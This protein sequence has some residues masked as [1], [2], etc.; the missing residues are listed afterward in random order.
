MSTE[1]EL[2]EE[3][4]RSRLVAFDAAV[5]LRFPGRAFQLTLVGGGALVLLGCLAR[6]TADLDA[7]SVPRELVDLMQQFDIN[8]R[9]NAYV[10]NFAYGFEDRLV[11]LDLETKAVQC[12]AA[13]LEDI[14]AAKLHSSRPTDEHDVRRPEV[15]A[16]LDWERLDLVAEDMRESSLNDR[17]YAEFLRNYAEFREAFGPCVD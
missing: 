3:A 12:Y 2:G 8:C 15:L 6:A 9:V 5:H 10:N 17:N 14:V 11:P 16:V 7:L 13:S 4:L 1:L